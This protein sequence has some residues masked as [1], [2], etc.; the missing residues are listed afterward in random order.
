MLGV[1]T[2]GAYLDL[3]TWEGYILANAR[4]AGRD[5]RLAPQLLAA[6]QQDMEG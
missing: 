4:L 5:P 2:D 3:G 6:L 1:V